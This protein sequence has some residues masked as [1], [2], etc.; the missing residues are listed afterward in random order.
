MG[1]IHR[2]LA[3]AQLEKLGDR[4]KSQ[5]RMGEANRFYG[6]AEAC[7]KTPGSDQA[8]SLAH[9]EF[10]VRHRR[11]GE[12]I[13]EFERLRAKGN[14]NARS[15]M[16]LALVS[17]SFRT[18]DRGLLER[19]ERQIAQAAEKRPH[20]EMLSILAT[21]QDRTAEYDAAEQTY[22]RLDPR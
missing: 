10:L 21:I 11:D 9:M 19:I 17:I 22:R 13:D 12:A 5:Q 15:R 16:C 18:D 3:T 8:A 14:E 4:L 2:R 20:V 1:P 6:E 7:L